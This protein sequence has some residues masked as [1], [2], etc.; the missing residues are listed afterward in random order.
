M[1][2]FTEHCLYLKK[3][4]DDIGDWFSKRFWNFELP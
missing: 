1:L 3:G 4:K 2:N